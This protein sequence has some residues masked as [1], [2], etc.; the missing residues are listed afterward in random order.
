MSSLRRL[1]RNVIKEKCYK[2]NGNTSKFADE[3]NT[4]RTAK[5]GEEKVPAST[6]PKKKRHLDKAKDFINAMRYQK[7]MIQ[8]YMAQKKAE[9][10]AAEAQEV[11]E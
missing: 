10:D 8:N 3:W 2:Q 9:K 5:F 11:T 7:M 6:M 4:Y 1:E